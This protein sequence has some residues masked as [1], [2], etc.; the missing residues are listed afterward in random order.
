MYS[1]VKNVSLQ[2]HH[3]GEVRFKNQ[4]KKAGLNLKESPCTPLSSANHLEYTNAWRREIPYSNS[5]AT[6][7]T[8]NATIDNIRDAVQRIYANNPEYLD[9]FLKFINGA[10]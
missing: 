3:L 8:I 4:F 1:E 2:T 9:A 7:T 10:K 6:T 5:R